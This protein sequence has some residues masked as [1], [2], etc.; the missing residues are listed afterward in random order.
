MTYNVSAQGYNC[1]LQRN[2]RIWL[3]NKFCY[4]KL[5]NFQLDT[6]SKINSKTLVIMSYNSSGLEL[7]KVQ[8]V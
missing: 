3:Q 1:L 8:L 4:D 7:R 5:D 2:R 6:I